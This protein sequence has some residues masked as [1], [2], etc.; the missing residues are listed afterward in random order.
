MRTTIKT[1]FSKLS[2][3]AALILCVAA[4][5]AFLANNA[6]ATEDTDTTEPNTLPTITYVASPDSSLM[7]YVKVE[8][9][10]PIPEDQS[11]YLVYING[12]SIMFRA[13]DDISSPV[14][15][16]GIDTEALKTS[17]YSFDGYYINGEKKDGNITI[18]SDRQIEVRFKS[19]NINAQVRF[20][21]GSPV[22]GFTLSLYDKDHNFIE[23]KTTDGSGKCTFENY[24]PI[25]FDYTVIGTKD[26]YTD[27]VAALSKQM[28]DPFRKDISRNYT[29]NTIDNRNCIIQGE[30]KYHGYFNFTSSNI[31][32]GEVIEQAS[33][34]FKE[35]NL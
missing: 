13:A 22:Q 5:C 19:G 33:G 30:D 7:Q 12:A 23:A 3:L 28:I 32:G 18:S 25:K 10:R 34:F 2:L 31:L 9:K 15:L 35:L 17:G 26:G 16:V 29:V 21:D 1:K 27:I 14:F 8:Q 11:E 4:A 24:D 6:F 20:A